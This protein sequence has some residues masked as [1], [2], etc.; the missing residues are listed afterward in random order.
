MEEDNE[1]A[2][3]APSIYGGQSLSHA[4]DLTDDKSELIDL[5]LEPDQTLHVHE[6][7]APTQ[8]EEELP[9]EA[10][11]FEDSP[12]YGWD[13]FYQS[14]VHSDESDDEDGDDMHEDS[15][16]DDDCG[17]DCD[18]DGELREDEESS[19]CSDIDDGMDVINESEEEGQ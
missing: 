16:V 7:S 1:D 11:P 12:T 15:E 17:H 3:D 2:E 13:S 9:T 4:V 18:D 10:A 14:S 5:T 6:V 19:L 8:V